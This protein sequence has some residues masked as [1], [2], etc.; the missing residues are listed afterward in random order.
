VIVDTADFFSLSSE[1]MAVLSLE[2]KILRSNRALEELLGISEEKLHDLE[3][4]T[5]I[6][7]D[8]IDLWKTA[9]ARMENANTPTGFEVRC[10]NS[11]IGWV[12]LRWKCSPATNGTISAVARDVT[13]GRERWHR[14]QQLERML[15]AVN[16]EAWLLDRDARVVQTNSYVQ[17]ILRKSGP[18]MIGFTREEL[19]P[20]F[21]SPAD[22]LAESIQV[23]ASGIP[24]W[25][26]LERWQM[27]NEERWTMVDRTP[28]LDEDGV[29]E[30]VIVFGYDVTPQ[31]QAEAEFRRL[32]EQLE[33]R[34][35]TRTEELGAANTALSASEDRLRRIF[36]TALDAV[37]F[38]GADGR[39]T[40]WNNTAE[41]I[42]GLS[43][44][45]AEGKEVVDLICPPDART[46][47]RNELAE[48]QKNGTGEMIGRITE[49]VAQRRD[50][51]RFPAEVAITPLETPQ[52][53][54]LTIFLRDISQRHEHERQIIELNHQL[55]HR[56]EESTAANR[57]LEA[58]CYSVSHDLRSPLRSMD[59]FSQALIED[60]GSKLDEVGQDYLGR[61][62][63]ATQRMGRLID[64]LLNLSRVS[65]TELRRE[66]VNLSAIANQIAEELSRNSERDVKWEIEPEVMVQ[67]DPSLLRIVLENLLG[68]SWKYTSRKPSAQI[69]FGISQKDADRVIF[70]RDDGAGFDM[71]FADKLFKPFN[72]L[73]GATEFE[74]TG[75]GL[76][77]V[78]RILHRHNGRVWAEGKVGEGAAFYFIL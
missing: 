69:Q 28:L 6:Y 59:G 19:K 25:R 24:S 29:A 62:R 46:R 16:A 14:L 10:K 48:S 57:E 61:V 12:W 51:T 17:T 45:E 23:I 78:Q 31:I 40:G 36:S 50:E 53:F 35:L 75:I 54:H 4:A 18:E 9:L 41:K 11:G 37:I 39:C 76:A 27:G 67:G 22:R 26:S 43:A 65:R 2:G 74:G 38:M 77:T 30:G 58:F 5:F 52:G 47:Y 55:E 56:I 33:L 44:A 32:N 21:D 49:I 13:S 1:P 34:V 63:S 66:Q 71:T 68:N 7:A 15:N 8:D 70:I 73:H 20:G 64:D 42:F 72:R 3:P 60:Y